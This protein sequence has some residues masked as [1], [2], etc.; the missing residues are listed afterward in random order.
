MQPV[1]FNCWLHF[2]KGRRVCGNILIHGH[3]VEPRALSCRLEIPCRTLFH[4]WLGLPSSSK[5]VPWSD[6]FVDLPA[7]ICLH[8]DYINS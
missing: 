5:R 1:K 4:S 3:L 7:T 6:D 2:L 8:N